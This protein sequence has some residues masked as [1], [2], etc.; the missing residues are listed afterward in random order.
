MFRP[1]AIICLLCVL[2]GQARVAWA[3][4]LV[5][6]AENQNLETVSGS[7]PSATINP[8]SLVKIATSLW[9]LKKLGAEHRFVTQWRTSAPISRSSSTIDGDL[10]VSGGADPD[11]QIENAF[12]MAR[13]LNRVGIVNVA[14][15][16]VVGDNFWI[17]WEH[18]S[19][20]RLRDSRR[21]G[22]LM[23]QRLLRA[24]DPRV[25]TREEI[26]TWREFAQRRGF[27]SSRPPSL[28]IGGR[29]IYDPQTK[30]SGLLVE[31]RSRPL[32]EILR[33]FNTHSNNDIERLETVLGSPSDLARFITKRLASKSDIIFET[34][35]GLG[36]NSLIL[37]DIVSLLREV[38]LE[39]ERQ[40]H[41]PA[42]LFAVMNCEPSTLTKLFRHL[43]AGHIADGMTAK[44]G[45]L[46]TTDGGISALAGWLESARG[47]IR[48][49]VAAPRSGAQ[50][51]AARRATEKWIEHR[52]AQPTTFGLQS[53]PAPSGTSDQG[54]I[55]GDGEMID[56]VL[57][58]KSSG[59]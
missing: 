7:R 17:G 42:D 9:A 38:E 30:A 40:N 15:N 19:A 29:A 31:H 14:G 18:G 34:T 56:P 13:R 21:R 28:K 46:T 27:D 49:V 35:S 54:A 39:L 48:F 36:H 26:K 51:W 55:V 45:T 6:Y 47:L 8:A 11:F 57:M 33:R 1:L 4:D 20:G 43:A 41:H 44:T 23:A 12:L 50:L 37:K 53:C 24:I 22:A 3:I 2:V 58:G 10:V 52:Q 5:W 25:R 32:I 59:N 16:L